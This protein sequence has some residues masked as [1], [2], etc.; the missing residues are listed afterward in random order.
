MEDYAINQQSTLSMGTRE[1]CC[2][3]SSPKQRAALQSS[4]H[5]PCAQSLLPFEEPEPTWGEEEWIC[6]AVSCH[7]QS[8]VCSTSS[9]SL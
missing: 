1:L 9:Q 8:S 7:A 2:D 4:L 6:S 3:Q 5:S